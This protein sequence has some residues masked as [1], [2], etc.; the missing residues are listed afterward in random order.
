MDEA[1][2]VGVGVTTPF[3]G[4][5]EDVG[6]GVG[7]APPLVGVTEGVGDGVGVAPPFVGDEEGVPEEELVELGDPPIVAEAL[8]VPD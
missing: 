5:T 6:E 4:E 3:V 1:V 7:E 8:R 2:G